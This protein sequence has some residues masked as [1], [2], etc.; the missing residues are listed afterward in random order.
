MT[1]PSEARFRV[2]L[3]DL[4]RVWPLLLLGPAAL[5][6]RFTYDPQTWILGAV[7]IGLLLQLAP[8]WRELVV[9]RELILIAG[10]VIWALGSLMWSPDAP[11]GVRLLVS[12][13]VVLLAYLWGTVSGPPGGAARLWLIG[14]AGLMFALVAL[15]L[16]PNPPPIDALSPN[17]ML[18]M[19]LIA[20]TVASWYGPRSRMYVALVGLSALGLGVLSGSRTASFVILVLLIT[21]PGLRLPRAG[22]IIGALLL[23]SAFLLASTTDSFQERWSESDAGSLFEVITFQDLDSSGRFDVWPEL[24]EECGATILGNGTGAADS[25][26]RN[27]N[28]GFPEPHNEYIRVWCDTGI[29]GTLLLWGFLASIAVGAVAGLRTGGVGNWAHVA[30]IQMAVSLWLMSLT[31]NPLTTSVLFMIPA[32]LVFGWSHRVRK[33]QESSRTHQR[34]Q[35]WPRDPTS[36]NRQPTTVRLALDEEG[37]RCGRSLAI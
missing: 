4:S 18:G 24:V 30:A 36:D 27:I 35:Q 22:R 19:G 9:S 15:V 2:H 23:T 3:E 34:L 21:A 1:P 31:D 6:I 26:S 14:T 8:R 29:P 33:Q 25:Y 37:G 20:M 10:F 32:A 16:T 12:I 17:R 11:R 28:P 7:A 13:A 5:A